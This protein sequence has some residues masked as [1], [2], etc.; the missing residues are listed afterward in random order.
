MYNEIGCEAN[1]GLLRRCQHDVKLEADSG[2]FILRRLG[3]TLEVA[4]AAGVVLA[5]SIQPG[6][7]GALLACIGLGGIGFI[8]TL[9]R[10]KQ[11]EKGE[12]GL[13]PTRLGGVLR[14]FV[15]AFVQ[16]VPLSMAVPTALML[17]RNGDILGAAIGWIAAAAGGSATV[18]HLIEGVQRLVS[19]PRLPP[20][21]EDEH[22]LL[23]TPPDGRGEARPIR[24]PPR[25]T[26]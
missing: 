17:A 24:G 3:E 20:G 1:M 8:Q 13:K 19:Q 22:P 25:C 23:P 9:R 6:I 14:E 12:P 2:P 26:L 10:R 7:L 16:F 21:E 15:G 5:F 18:F 4:V 11:R